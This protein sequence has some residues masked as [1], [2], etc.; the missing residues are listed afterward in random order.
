N[1]HMQYVVCAD[2]SFSAPFTSGHGILASDSASPMFWLL[3]MSDLHLPDDPADI[4]LDG[5]Y[6]SH[7]EHTDDIVLFSMCPA[8]LQRKLDALAHW[9]G[10]NFLIINLCKSISMIFGRLPS[11]LPMLSID[12]SVLH[13]TSQYTYIGVTFCSTTCNIF[14]PHYSLKAQKAKSLANVTFRL[15]GLIGS[16][17]AWEG[18]LLYMA[19]VDPHL[20]H[21]CDILP[22]VDAGLL[23]PLE[24]VQRTFVQHLLAAA[25]LPSLCAAAAS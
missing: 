25:M 10:L 1:A 22:D 18:H 3:F 5:I 4:S 2:G 17:P 15:D 6:V 14:S 21:A 12:G 23:Q 16:L 19:C 24:N 13:W 11:P 8:A 9:C 20:M 7:L